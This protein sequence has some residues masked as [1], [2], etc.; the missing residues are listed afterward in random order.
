MVRSEQVAAFVQYMEREFPE[1]FATIIHAPEDSASRYTVNGRGGDGV[2]VLVS[3]S[4]EF[5]D[6]RAPAD[7]RRRLEEWGVAQQAR[8]AS[9]TQ[10]VL[11]TQDGVRLVAR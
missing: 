1:P 8:E 4:Y 5:L 10:R 6:N 3:A 9:R 2:Q 7:I 11:V